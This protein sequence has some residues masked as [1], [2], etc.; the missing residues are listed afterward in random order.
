MTDAHNTPSPLRPVSPE[1]HQ[2]LVV[3]KEQCISLTMNLVENRFPVDLL[4]VYPDTDD[5]AVLYDQVSDLKTCLD[6][7]RPFDSAQMRK[8]QEAFDTEYT[9]ESNR[10]ERNSLTLQKTNF[11]INEGLTICN[12]SMREH[13]EAINHKEAIGF[14]RE[15]VSRYEPVTERTIKLIHALILHGIDRENAGIYRRV[16]VSIRGTAIVF[17]NPYVVSPSWKT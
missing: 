1:E 4:Q 6:S 7:F 16:S 10:I 11:V 3:M 9:Y 2:E 8:L 13:L 5:L 14:I 15:L 12:K 17:P